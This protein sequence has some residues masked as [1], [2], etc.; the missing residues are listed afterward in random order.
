MSAGA[1]SL[2]WFGRNDDFSIPRDEDGPVFRAPWEAEA[3]ALAISLNERGLFTWKEWAARLG[4]EIKKAQAAGDPDTGDTY[5]HHW[6][7]TLERIV[8]AQGFGIVAFLLVTNVVLLA[9]GNFMDPAAITLIMAPILFPMAAALGVHPVHLGILMAV[10]M[11]VGLCHPPVGLNL[12]VASGI[13]KMGITELTIAVLPWL[14][15]M[16]IFLVMVTYIPE[17]SLWLPRVLGML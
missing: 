12:Y 4:D 11:E 2:R 15:T 16:L 14:G 17:I 5:Y 1:H 7:A 8:A 6:L 3:F 10:N 9:A 13:T